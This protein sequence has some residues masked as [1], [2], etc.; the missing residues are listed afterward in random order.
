M[1]GPKLGDEIVLCKLLPFSSRR[2]PFPVTSCTGYSD[3]TQPSLWHME[4][5]AWVLRSDPSRS[6]IGFI[7]ARRMKE[8]DRHVLEED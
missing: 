6:R 4:E 8:E 7:E 1:K 3:R 5:I 2:V